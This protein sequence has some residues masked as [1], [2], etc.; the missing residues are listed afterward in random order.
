MTVIGADRDRLRA[1]HLT[2]EGAVLVYDGDFP[3]RAFRNSDSSFVVIGI[4]I[5]D[6]ETD[7]AGARR[8]R[9]IYRAG[10]NVSR[11][12]F[13]R[14]ALFVI[15][16]RRLIDVV[17]G[18]GLRTPI[19]SKD[20]SIFVVGL[21]NERAVIVDD[22]KMTGESIVAGSALESIVAVLAG[23]RIVAEPADDEIIRLRRSC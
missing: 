12:K 14:I 2:R 11:R 23:D 4:V 15:G 6:G 1:V 3:S 17:A 13:D 10:R 7:G 19:R 9:G 16:D 22:L 18:I 20:E 5:D 21:V 8:R